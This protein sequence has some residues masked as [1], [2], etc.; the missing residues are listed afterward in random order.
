[1]N[2]A[3]L[4]DP[5]LAPLQPLL[6]ALPGAEHLAHGLAA[7]HACVPGELE[8][9]RFPD[10][11]S[12]PRFH[13]ALAGRHVVLAAC[14]GE[15]DAKLFELYLCASI[16][17][18]LGARSVGLLLP[19]LPYMRQDSIFAEG[20]GTSALHVGRLLSSCADW[21]V[22]V[23]PHL[24][25]IHQL[26]DAYQIPATVA[27]SAFALADW[28]RDNVDRPMI[29]GPD[30]ESAQW[31]EHVAQLVGCPSMVMEKQRHGDRQV[32]ISMGQS[33]P[34]AGHTPVLLDDIA[35]SGRTMAGAVER[36]LE[37]GTQPPVCLVVHPL[38]GTGALDLLERAHARRIV[39]CNT[40]HHSTN[41]VDICPALAAGM[42]A[43]LRQLEQR[44]S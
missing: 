40:L 15:P 41:G 31:V 34:V 4:P 37:A 23:D 43:Q 29:V 32:S 17:R 18:E 3:H 38:F 14:M 33:V 44:N 19:Y 7:L 11:E 36:L 26:S 8:L 24:H 13:A 27:S 16:A 12:C 20:Q 39:S 30:W 22:T 42:A 28:I 35:S 2:P 25:R 9:H 10:G 1:M 21:L 5:D 6:F